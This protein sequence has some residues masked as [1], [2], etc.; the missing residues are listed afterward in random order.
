MLE[1]E[2]GNTRNVY[3]HNYTMMYTTKNVTIRKCDNLAFR[4]DDSVTLQVANG[5]GSPYGSDVDTVVDA[6]TALVLT[7]ILVLSFRSLALPIT[8]CIE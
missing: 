4:C 7:V 8:V 3:R 5:W 6:S 2:L 1:Q